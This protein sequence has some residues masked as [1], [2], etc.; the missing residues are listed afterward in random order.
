MYMRYLDNNGI[1]LNR[2]MNT[3]WKYLKCTIGAFIM[4]LLKGGREKENK[5]EMIMYSIVLPVYSLQERV[6]DM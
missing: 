5:K 3:L 2:E 4:R 1:V 6:R